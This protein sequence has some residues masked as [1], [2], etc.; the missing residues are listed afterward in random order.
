MEQGP[1]NLEGVTVTIGGEPITMLP[2]SDGFTPEPE[3]ER[4]PETPRQSININGKSTT[5]RDVDRAIAWVTSD[6]TRPRTVEVE[7]RQ[8]SGLTVVDIT[9]HRAPYVREVEKVG[10]NAPCPCGSGKKFKRCCR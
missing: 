3:P 8:V 4:E 1:Y 9:T 10:R 7:T 2:F 6:P 5:F